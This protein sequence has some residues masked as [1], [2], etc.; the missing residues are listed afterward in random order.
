L[1]GAA[2]RALGAAANQFERFAL[3]QRPSDRF[4][5]LFRLARPQRLTHVTPTFAAPSFGGGSR[6]SAA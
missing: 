3:R 4:F 5:D 1:R 6:I 2:D